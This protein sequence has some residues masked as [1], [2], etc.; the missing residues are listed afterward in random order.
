MATIVTGEQSIRIGNKLAEIQRQLYLQR[1]GY[2]YDP[3]ILDS[4]LQRVV[5]GKF[6]D[7]QTASQLLQR[8]TSIKVLAV[9]QFVASDRFKENETVNGVKFAWFG[10]NF[11]ANFL[12]KVE[13]EVEACEIKI[14]TLL[15]ASRDL[16]IRSE[17]GEEQEETKLAHL[18]QLLKFQ[19]NGGKGALLTNGYANIFYIRDTNGVLWAVVARWHG[20]GWILSAYSIG[21]AGVWDADGR[22]CA[23]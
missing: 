17:I 1:G 20:D 16:V 18:W 21:H 19:E 10:G 2:P 6:N 4:F 12:D 22:V 23:R 9:N 11:K 5:E 7:Q 8:V 15:R 14:H 13:T 3:D